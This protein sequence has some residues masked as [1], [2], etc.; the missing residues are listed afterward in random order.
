[1]KISTPEEAEAYFIIKTDDRILE[2]ETKLKRLSRTK[3]VALVLIMVSVFV[4]VGVYWEALQQPASF[5]MVFIIITPALSGQE[6]LSAKRTKLLLELI[7]LKT[8]N[9]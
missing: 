6:V 2:I 7:E 3:N 5:L 4:A 9:V 1:M 8:K